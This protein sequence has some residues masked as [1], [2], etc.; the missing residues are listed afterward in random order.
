MAWFGGGTNKT[1]SIQRKVLRVGTLTPLQELD[2]RRTQE[3][4]TVMVL[5]QLFE[6]PYELAGLGG[7]PTPRLFAE[8]LRAEEGGNVVSAAVRQGIVFSDGTPLTAAVVAESLASNEV[9]L[10]AAAVEAVGERLRFRLHRPHPGFERLLA[11]SH[12]DVTL[13][14]DGHVLGTGPFVAEEDASDPQCVR[15][16]PNPNYRDEVPLD[17]V[18]YRVYASAEQ[19]AAAVD[20]GEVDLTTA[21]SRDD[22]ARVREARKHFLPGASTAIL[23]LNTE[24][25]AFADP[26]RRRAVAFA[27]DR[28]EVTR[29][30]YSSPLAFSAMSLLPPLMGSHRDGVSFAPERARELLREAGSTDGRLRLVIVW[31]PRPYLPQPAAAASTLARQLAAVGLQVDVVTPASNE[32][33]NDRIRAADYDLLL[34]GWIA[35]THDPADFLAANLSSEAIPARAASTV[36]RANRARWRDAAVDQ[37]LG[38]FRESRSGEALAEIFERVRDGVPFVPLMYGQTVVVCGWRVRNFEPTPLGLSSLASVD[39][40]AS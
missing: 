36:G 39:V 37:A 24:R 21:L 35:D 13:R 4:G 26:R 9:V 16:F 18:Q 40:E 10:R 14:R 17:E 28:V 31:A 38:R 11:Q 32:E 7:E 5:A 1:K 6:A 8:P 34:S 12:C 30:S 20:A 27:I 15:L 29:T 3:R 25:P 19:L 22:V 33:Y 23:Y 2:P